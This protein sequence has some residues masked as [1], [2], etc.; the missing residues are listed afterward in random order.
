MASGIAVIMWARLRDRDVD[1]LYTDP[2]VSSLPNLGK[3]DL[4][5]SRVIRDNV[6]HSRTL[7]GFIMEVPPIPGVVGADEWLSGFM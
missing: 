5:R 2:T 1:W 7:P 6:E 4:L 3:P